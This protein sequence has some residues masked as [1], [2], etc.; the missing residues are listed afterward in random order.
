M[1]LKTRKD[2]D[3]VRCQRPG[4]VCGGEGVPFIRATCHPEVPVVKV[5]YDR[6][7]GALVVKCAVCGED[8]EAIAVAGGGDDA[9]TTPALC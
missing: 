5:Y 6:D 7:V 9:E 8:I 3:A 4:C 2:L 1:I